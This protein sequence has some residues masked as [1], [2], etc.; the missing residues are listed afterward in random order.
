MF[1]RSKN[2]GRSYAVLTINQNRTTTTTACVSNQNKLRSSHQ[3]PIQPNYWIWRHQYSLIA[4]VTAYDFTRTYSV[5]ES[6]LKYSPFQ[7]SPWRSTRVRS[8]PYEKLWHHHCN[9]FGFVT[10]VSIWH[11]PVI[12]LYYMAQ[13]VHG[14]TFSIENNHHLLNKISWV[15]LSGQC[16]TSKKKVVTLHPETN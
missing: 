5:G 1:Q 4:S 15:R 16:L 7:L 6:T 12:A 2:L 14:L 3:S 10:D 8:K 13:D 9:W 11:H